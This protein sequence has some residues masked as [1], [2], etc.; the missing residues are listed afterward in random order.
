MLTGRRRLG[1]VTSASAVLVQL[2]VCVIRIDEK[3]FSSNC[4]ILVFTDRTLFTALFTALC[5][6]SSASAVVRELVSESYCLSSRQSNGQSNCQS[7]RLS[8]MGNL[9]SMGNLQRMGDRARVR[10]PEPVP[11]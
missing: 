11:E 3:G 2:L 10:E 4:I 7:Y 6:G 5:R 9:Q 1:K 8:T